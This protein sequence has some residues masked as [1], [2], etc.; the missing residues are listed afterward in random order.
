MRLKDISEAKAELSA[1]L[2]AVARGEEVIIARGGVAVARLVRY[3]E[4]APKRPEVPYK[5]GPPSV[6]I[7]VANDD[8]FPEALAKAAGKKLVP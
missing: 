3:E 2:D 6:K 4:Q 1:L 5:P 8:V 7:S